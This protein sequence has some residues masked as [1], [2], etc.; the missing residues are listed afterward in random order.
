[1]PIKKKAKVVK[2]K[3]PSTLVVSY[4]PQTW[5]SFAK[6]PPR[7][8]SGY[9]PSGIDLWIYRPGEGIS[10]WSNWSGCLTDIKELLEEKALWCFQVEPKLPE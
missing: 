1:M 4:L 7:V 5:K 10:S 6:P 8:D 9:G 3:A 2:A